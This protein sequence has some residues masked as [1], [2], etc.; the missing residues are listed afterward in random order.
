MDHSA[1][2]IT[3]ALRSEPDIAPDARYVGEVPFPEAA[4]IS[5]VANA[6]P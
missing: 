5:A 2:F 6:S 1:A 4:E 3:S